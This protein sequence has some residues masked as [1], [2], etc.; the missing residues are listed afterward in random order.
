MRSGG[1]VAS[2][3]EIEGGVKF[4]RKEL[5]VEEQER[6]REGGRRRRTHEWVWKEKCQHRADALVYM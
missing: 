1:G 2:E 5:C 4:W 3:G 6:M